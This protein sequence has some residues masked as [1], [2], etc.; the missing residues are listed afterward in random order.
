MAVAPTMHDLRPV[1]LDQRDE[2]P[3]VGQGLVV[4]QPGMV[5]QIHR[6]DPVGDQSL[7]QRTDACARQHRAGLHAQAIGQ[8]SRLAA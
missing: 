3:G 5:D 6:V 8:F 2:H 4:R 1:L 7:R